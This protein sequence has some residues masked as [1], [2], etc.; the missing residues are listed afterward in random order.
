MKEAELLSAAFDPAA[1]CIVLLLRDGPP[2]RLVAGPGALFSLRRAMT[3]GFGPMAE[4][5][6][7]RFREAQHFGPIRQPVKSS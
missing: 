5:S 4:Q 2:V 1:R 6:A 7:N 3:D